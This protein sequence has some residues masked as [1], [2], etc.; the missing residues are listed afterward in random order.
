MSSTA[1]LL[2]LPEQLDQVA[3]GGKPGAGTVGRT[4]S[5]AITATFGGNEGTDSIRTN[6]QKG[7]RR[8]LQPRLRTIFRVR[9]IA[10]SARARLRRPA[11]RQPTEVSA[12]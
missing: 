9:E 8:A 3:G 4:A 11:C 10:P 7:K 12:F 5:F 1:A 6:Q 2:K